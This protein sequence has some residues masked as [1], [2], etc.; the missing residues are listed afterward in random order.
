[1]TPWQPRLPTDE[2][3]RTQAS[4][5]AE[6]A[7]TTTEQTDW[8]AA[9]R[10]LWK[11]RC[12]NAFQS[13][14]GVVKDAAPKTW[15]TANLVSEALGCRL[16]ERPARRP[17]LQLWAGTCSRP[18]PLSVSA[19]AAMATAV[20]K[21]QLCLAGS[22]GFR[23]GHATTSW[24]SGQDPAPHFSGSKGVKKLHLLL[25]GSGLEGGRARVRTR[26]SLRPLPSLPQAGSGGQ[27]LEER[28]Q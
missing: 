12:Q 14:M 10:K 25:R 3:R 28:G 24:S 20:S 19:S 7:Q 2:S 5:P 22:Q 17:L 6:P 16:A 26:L 8:P 4:P 11:I 18:L 9:F 21:H 13:S 23:H 15:D 1:M 27:A